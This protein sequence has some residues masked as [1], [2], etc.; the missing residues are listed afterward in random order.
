MAGR[1]LLLEN[2]EQ[3]MYENPLRA[4]FQRVDPAFLQYGG[5]ADQPAED[6]RPGCRQV[7]GHPHR[8]PSCWIPS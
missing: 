2:A 8:L 1:Y 5:D 4:G 6:E 7:Q 3:R